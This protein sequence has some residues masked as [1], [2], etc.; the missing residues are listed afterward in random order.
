[1]KKL[2]LLSI[3]L[4]VPSFAKADYRVWKSSNVTVAANSL[5]VLC[6]EGQRGIFHG[7][8]TDFGVA[9]SS[10][11]IHNSTWTLTATQ[12]A[13]PISTLVADQCKYYD[14]FT[15]NGLSYFKNNTASVTI[16]YDCF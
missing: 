12:A 8:C 7:Q 6:G 10:M 13:G 11:T 2:L 16:M 4:L 14:I 9:S 1:M 5:K 3:A 15:P